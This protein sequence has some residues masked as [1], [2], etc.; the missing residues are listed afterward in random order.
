M[1][2]EEGR[3]DGGREGGSE[4][5]RGVQ[6][7]ARLPCERQT[8]VA[9]PTVSTST[10]WFALLPAFQV[11]WFGKATWSGMLTVSRWA[12]Q[13]GV[14]GNTDRTGHQATF[15]TFTCSRTTQINTLRCDCMIVGVL[16]SPVPEFVVTIQYLICL[17][18]VLNSMA[19]AP[20]DISNS[21]VYDFILI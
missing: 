2:V 10:L 20:N 1:E 5:G 7:E 11:T 17:I 3:R 19:L 9:S 14:D 6:R 21:I 8:P 12:E 4:E 15:S 13:T 16:A 18:N